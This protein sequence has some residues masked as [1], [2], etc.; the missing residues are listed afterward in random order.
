MFTIDEMITPFESISLDK[1]D[2]VK[3]LDRIDSKFIFKSAK[4]PGILAQL[5]AAY[6]ILEV[7]EVRLQRYETLYFDTPGHQLYLKHHNKRRNRFKIRCRKYVDSGL[8]YFEIKFKNNKG[9]T[10]KERNRQKGSQEEITG[11]QERLLTTATK[12]TPDMLVPSLWVNFSRI[13]LVNH[14]LSERVTIDTGLNFR[15]G[16]AGCSFPGVVIAEVKRSRS[17]SSGISEILHKEHIHEIK[18]SKYC[19][20]T[21]SL[22]NG[23]KYNNFKQK[24]LYLNKLNHDNS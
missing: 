12:M 2:E 14:G 18:F 23:I 4:L 7:G 3:L 13:T 9:R 10:I 1:M 19:M 22:N 11:K 24:L 6:F 20:G 16:A 15:N 21:L 5:S 8:C 17:G